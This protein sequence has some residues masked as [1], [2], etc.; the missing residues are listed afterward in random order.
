VAEVHRGRPAK[1]GESTCSESAWVTIVIKDESPGVP[2]IFSFKQV[3]GT[4]P[5]EMF[6]PGA[7]SGATYADGGRAFVFH[8]PDINPKNS[9]ALDLVVR[10]TPFTRS[11][12]EG[13]STDL[14]VRD[15]NP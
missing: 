15:G 7:Y 12:I 6:S 5:D 1:R 13:P 8:W 4:A 14:V 11:G 2:Y 3:S 10:I 9:P